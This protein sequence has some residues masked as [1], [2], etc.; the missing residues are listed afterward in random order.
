MGT[1]RREELNF[2]NWKRYGR[3]DFE[4]VKGVRG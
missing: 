3:Q 4:K 2:Q 1:D